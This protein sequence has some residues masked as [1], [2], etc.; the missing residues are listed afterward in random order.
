MPESTLPPLAPRYS[1]RE[2]WASSVIHA[3]GI[4]LSVAGLIALATVAAQGGNAWHLASVCIY[5]ISLILLY[6]ASTLYHAIPHPSAKQVLRTLDHVGIFLLI[7]GTYTPFTVISLQGG[8]GWGLFGVVWTLAAI[9]IVLELRQ[10]RRR[11]W[12]IAL[13]VGMGWVGVAAI[14]PLM[15]S[16]SSAGLWLLLGGGL[17]YTLGVP[18]YLWRSLP[19]NHA[20]WHLFVLAGSVLHFC[21]IYFHVLPRAA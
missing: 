16:L 18:F 13:Y 7:A 10:V 1:A 21:A 20:L 15:A 19:Y 12:L 14:G 4:A 2:E 3:I 11:G 9:G 5:G 6:V 8:W 17:C